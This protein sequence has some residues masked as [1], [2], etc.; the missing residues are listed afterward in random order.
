MTD[1]SNEFQ[2][3][4][5]I[6]PERIEE[7]EVGE[8]P[9]ATR[10]IRLRC[11][12]RSLNCRA[13]CWR[14]AR[15]VTAGPF[16]APR[17]GATATASSSCLD[18]WLATA[19]RCHSDAFSAARIS[20]P[21]AGG[22]ARTTAVSSSRKRCS[23]ASKHCWPPRQVESVWWV[24]VSVVSM[25]GLL[26]THWPERDPSGHHARQSIRLPRARHGKQ[27]GQSTIPVH[28]GHVDRR[29]ARSDARPCRSARSTGDR[30]LQPQR[31]RRALDIVRR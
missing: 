28:V 10:T 14:W 8:A 18:S 17:P 6:D 22:L 7:W 19:R 31:W 11:G 27:R 2:I 4:E 26:A 23:S 24:R 25:P 30:H 1:P 5:P 13:R 9:A 16:S 15:S 20:S 21:S 12:T 3:Y 29:D